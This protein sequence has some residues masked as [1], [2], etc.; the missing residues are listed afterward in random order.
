MHPQFVLRYVC[1]ERSK[2]GTN[3]CNFG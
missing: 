2:T 1:T 3:V